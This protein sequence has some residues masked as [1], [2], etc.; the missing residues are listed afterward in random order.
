M[1]L[2]DVSTLNEA[3][4]AESRG[5]LPGWLCPKVTKAANGQLWSLQ[6]NMLYLVCLIL[7]KTRVLKQQVVV[8]VLMQIKIISMQS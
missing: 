7:T 5:K 8:R 4:A 6:M 2:L 1:Q 3:A